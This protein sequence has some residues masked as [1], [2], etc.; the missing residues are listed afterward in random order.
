MADVEIPNLTEF[1]QLDTGD[2]YPIR[3]TSASLDKRLSWANLIA[4]FNTSDPVNWLAQIAKIQASV[5]NTQAVL[6][7][8]GDSWVQAGAIRNG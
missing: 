1:T 3:D 6:A 2:Y 8:I 7:V 4:N 5:S